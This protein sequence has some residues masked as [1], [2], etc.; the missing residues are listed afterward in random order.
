MA[1][2]FGLAKQNE[3]EDFAGCERT[4]QR[5]LYIRQGNG[6]IWPDQVRPY[7][8]GRSGCDDDGQEGA[9]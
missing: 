3:A 1:D 9:I 7:R 5:R 6:W 8:R 4:R 2:K